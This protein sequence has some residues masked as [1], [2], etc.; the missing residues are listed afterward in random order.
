MTVDL[1]QTLVAR[2]PAIAG[3]PLRLGSGRQTPRALSVRD[4]QTL[5]HFAQA[6]ER[7][8]TE[9]LAGSGYAPVLLR[10]AAG[11]E[12]AVLQVWQS[13]F[14]PVEIEEYTAVFAIFP[15]VPATVPAARRTVADDGSGLAPILTMLDVHDSPVDNLSINK[16]SLWLQRLFDSTT[17]LTW[18]RGFLFFPQII[19]VL[20]GIFAPSR[21]D[22]V[23]QRLGIANPHANTYGGAA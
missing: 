5:M 3:S 10:D 9:L 14:V 1:F 15:V 19:G 8:V 13:T 23:R 16:P 7:A 21:V 4:G 11:A 20:E 18:H 6:D 2:F 22:V 12:H 17:E